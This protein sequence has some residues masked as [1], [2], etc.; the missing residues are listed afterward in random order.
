MKMDADEES[1]C[2]TLAALD[3][4]RDGLRWYLSVI[5]CLAA[6]N[7]PDKVASFYQF[8]LSS[9]VLEGREFNETSMIREALTKLVGIVGAAKVGQ[10]VKV[11]MHWES[12]SL[13]LTDWKRSEGFIRCY[14]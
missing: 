10:S 12:K 3:N 4:P 8:L 11:L 9:C 1:F 5:S 2:R 6:L 14:A 7:H 13:H